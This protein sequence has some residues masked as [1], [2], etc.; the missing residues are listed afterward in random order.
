[1]MPPPNGLGYSEGT[2]LTQND[3]KGY[4]GVI[5]GVDACGVEEGNPSSKKIEIKGT[6]MVGWGMEPCS[7]GRFK[8]I[9]MEGYLLEEEEDN[10]VGEEK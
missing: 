9:E 4:W 8:M 2:S 6:V 1:M 5:N 3:Q 7:V 10:G